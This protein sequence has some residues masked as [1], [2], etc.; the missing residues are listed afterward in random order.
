M[1]KVLFNSSHETAIGLGVR[2]LQ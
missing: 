2:L 1:I